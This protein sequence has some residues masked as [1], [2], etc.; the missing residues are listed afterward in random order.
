[1]VLPLLGG[2][3]RG[4]GERLCISSHTSKIEA[5]QGANQFLDITISGHHNF[6]TSQFLDITISGH[7]SFWTSQFLDITVSGHHEC[8]HVL[9][10]LL[11]W[12]EER[13]GERRFV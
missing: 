7:H 2:E 4:E 1:M 5:L 12:M 6:W 3:G 13:A 11:H 9:L 10:P 8:P